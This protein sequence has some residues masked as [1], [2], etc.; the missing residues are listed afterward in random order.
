MFAVDDATADA[1][2]RTFEERGAFAAAV[3]LRKHFRGILDIAQARQQVRIIAGVEAHSA[4]VA[5]GWIAANNRALAAC[6]AGYKALRANDD[7]TSIPREFSLEGAEGSSRPC[8]WF[9]HPSTPRSVPAAAEAAGRRWWRET[10]C[11]RDPAKTAA[12]PPPPDT[13]P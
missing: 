13:P 10:R 12:T 3:E 11:K 5:A 7:E 1:I 9:K 6:L 2:R 4:A 8:P